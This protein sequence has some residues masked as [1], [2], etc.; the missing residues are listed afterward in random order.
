M[1][2]RHFLQGT[3]ATGV[4]VA[5]PIR[6]SEA[7]GSA[8]VARE[9]ATAAPPCWLVDEAVLGSAGDGHPALPADAVLLP[10]GTYLTPALLEP[11]VGRPFNALLAPANAVLLQS[12]LRGQR[13]VT[14]EGEPGREVWRVV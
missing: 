4:A 6:A 12:L 13:R 9:E 2:R 7:E 11:F 8:A 10:R 3:A 5:L 14:A 1:K